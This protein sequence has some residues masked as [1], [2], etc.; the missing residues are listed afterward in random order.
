MRRQNKIHDVE[1]QYN[2]G[3]HRKIEDTPTRQASGDNYAQ[4]TYGVNEATTGS[5]RIRMEPVNVSCGLRTV[6]LK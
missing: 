5:E 2:A 6:D 1:I 3:E 4:G